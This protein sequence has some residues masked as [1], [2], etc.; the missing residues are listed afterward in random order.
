MSCIN[1]ATSKAVAI[2]VG[3]NAGYWSLPLSIKFDKTLCIE[4]DPEMILKLKRN[5]SLNPVQKERIE[6][7]WGAATDFN[8]A[9][10]LN[11]RRSIDGDSRLNA[12]L[13]S[14]LLKDLSDSSVN[15]P[16]MTIDHLCRE[17]PDK[18][19]L[20]KIDVEGA[21]SLVLAG[22]LITN[23]QP[24]IVWE[25]TV[26]LDSRLGTEN[27]KTSL[28]FLSSL[29]YSHIAVAESLPL[30]RVKN[31]EEIHSLGQD[32]DVLSYPN[33]RESENLI[34][35]LLNFRIP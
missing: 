12:G 21:E 14:I 2:D 27:V 20:I 26:S 22:A 34:T 15:V 35:E 33:H 3:A 6:I 4:A 32:V 17:L 10:D 23:S 24:L 25:A 30:C 29:G 8:G 18:V 13:N 28:N 16:A 31:F 11:I 19:G 9:I 7:I 5:I 1:L